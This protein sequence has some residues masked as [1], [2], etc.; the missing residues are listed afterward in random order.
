MVTDELISDIRNR[1]LKG[2]RRYEIREDLIEEGYDED[3][4]D[5]AISHIQYDAIKQLPVLS[6]IFK[7]IEHY[8]SK[9][10]TSTPKTTVFIMFGCFAFL[11]LFA[12]GLYFLFDPLG[13]S[14]KAR[15]VTRQAD[16]TDIQNALTEYYQ[17][18]QLYPQTLNTL[19][20]GFIPSIPKDPQ[21]GASYYY[22]LINN[23]TNYE[24][25]VTFEVQARSCV[26][27][28]TASEAIPAV[29]TP[30]I[31]PSFVP[32]SANDTQKNAQ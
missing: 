26:S 14:S 16:Q 17:K 25:C 20:P 31:E 2:Q 6:W 13:T 19:A 32:Q 22:Q 29:P 4:I 3:D 30:T 5:D 1:F 8:E 28:A 12:G 21:T 24:L 7:H 23:N 10:G 15:D 18:N 9:P 27:G 11:F